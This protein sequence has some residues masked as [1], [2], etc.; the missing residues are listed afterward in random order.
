MDTITNKQTIGLIAFYIRKYPHQVIA[1]L[2]KYYT[3]TPDNITQTNLARLTGEA[4]QNLSFAKPFNQSM[5]TALS[6]HDEGSYEFLGIH[7]GKA[8]KSVGGW[9]GKNGGKVLSAVGGIFGGN[10]KNQSNPA[11]A[12]ASSTAGMQN[13]SSTNA[14]LAAMMAQNAAN[15]NNPAAIIQPTSTSHTG[16]YIVLGVAGLAVIGTIVALVMRK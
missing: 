9:I 11:P 1:L 7:L 12:P 8:I 14:L 15:A 3:A 16:L 13:N 4:L 10:N 5:I 2:N 6:T